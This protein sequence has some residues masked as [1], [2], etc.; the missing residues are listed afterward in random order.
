MYEIKSDGYLAL[1][2]PLA[3]TN[4]SRG[5]LVAYVAQRRKLA[6]PGPQPHIPLLQ[7]PS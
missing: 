2:D 6:V 1:S 4:Y 7:A 5:T 3:K